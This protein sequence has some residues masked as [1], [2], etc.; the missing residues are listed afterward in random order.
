MGYK[1]IITEAAEKQF[2]NLI[3]HLIYEFHNESAASHLLNNV[4]EIY[5][6][7]QQN[8]YQFPV[9]EN[10]LFTQTEYHKAIL[11]DMKYLV[12]FRI[13]NECVYIIGIFHQLENYVVHLIKSS[14]YI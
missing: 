1:L 4:Q 10:P 2:D 6:H 13:E 8:P 11:L 7:L 3:F 9:Y 5:E 12:L 14:D